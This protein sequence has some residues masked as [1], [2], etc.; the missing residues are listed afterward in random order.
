[1]SIEKRS[2]ARRKVP[3]P[4]WLVFIVAFSVAGPASRDNWRG[5]TVAPE[6]RC[7]PYDKRGDYS[8]PQSIEQEIVR[9]LGGVYGPYTGRCFGSR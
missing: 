8:H 4:S 2:R 9:E 1:M 7:S 5:L 6:H 3:M